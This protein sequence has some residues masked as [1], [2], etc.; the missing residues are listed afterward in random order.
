MY[1]ELFYPDLRMIYGWS[2]LLQHEWDRKH[3]I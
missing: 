2:L 1:E 3:E